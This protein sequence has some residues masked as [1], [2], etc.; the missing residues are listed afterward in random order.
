M[1]F[2]TKRRPVDG[3]RYGLGFKSKNQLPWVMIWKEWWYEGGIVDARVV[4]ST[5]CKFV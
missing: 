4:F 1:D 5:R 3:C 2:Y